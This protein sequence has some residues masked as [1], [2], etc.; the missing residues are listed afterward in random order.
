MLYAMA[1]TLDQKD[2]DVVLELD[3]S[4]APKGKGGQAGEYS[5]LVRDLQQKVPRRLPFVRQSHNRTVA[6][7]PS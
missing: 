5:L 4:Q 3:P 7:V 1:K 2:M 6:N